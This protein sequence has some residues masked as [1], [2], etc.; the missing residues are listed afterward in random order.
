MNKGKFIL[1]NGTFVLADE[2]RISQPDA[3]AIHFS[4]KF[5]AIRSAFPFF[6]ETLELIKLK[7]LLF[8]RSFPEFTG[9]D[10]SE[11]KRQLERTLTKN[12]HFLGAVLT[13]T[14]RLTEEK[15]TYTIQ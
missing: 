14:F 3:D 4:E 11:L 12:K 10:G 8:N 7:L 15:A 1:I 6:R 13:V 2:Y 5:R 9:N